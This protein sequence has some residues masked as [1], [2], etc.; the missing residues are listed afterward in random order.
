ML[1][2]YPL[3]LFFRTRLNSGLAF[4]LELC[5]R[6]LTVYANLTMASTSLR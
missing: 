3:N 2:F 4:L 1:V 5:N 6:Y